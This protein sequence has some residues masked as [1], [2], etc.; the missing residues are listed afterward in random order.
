MYVAAGAIVALFIV[1]CL[2]GIVWGT[3]S[4]GRGSGWMLL[5]WMAYFAALA[6]NIVREALFDSGDYNFNL[7]SWIALVLVGL[8]LLAYSWYRGAADMRLPSEP[9]WEALAKSKGRGEPPAEG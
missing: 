6:G 1:A 8:A 2:M 3:G 4:I 5:A 7:V 9:D